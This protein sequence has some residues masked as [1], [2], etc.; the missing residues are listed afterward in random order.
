MTETAMMRSTSFWSASRSGVIPAV[1]GGVQHC[2][3]LLRLNQS[4]GQYE[5]SLCH[6]IKLERAFQISDGGF[7]VRSK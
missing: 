2:K 7:R 3:M 6:A 1:I 4:K 5:A